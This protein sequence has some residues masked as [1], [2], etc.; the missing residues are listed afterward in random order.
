MPSAPVITIPSALVA[1]NT[2]GIGNAV[3]AGHDDAVSAG[4]DYS[5]GAG[6]EK[7]IGA[8]HDDAISAGHDDTVGTGHDYAVDEVMLMPA[9]V[10]DT[11]TNTTS[12]MAIDCFIFGKINLDQPSCV[13]N[14]YLSRVYRQSPAN[15]LA[16]CFR[17]WK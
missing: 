6:V 17:K 15:Y 16:R 13:A 5:V 3:S 7:T 8:G 4:H 10:G 11:N 14:Y 1:A 12:I 9:M 2:V